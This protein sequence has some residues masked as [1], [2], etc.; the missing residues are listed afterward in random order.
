M[1]VATCKIDSMSYIIALIVIW[2][3]TKVIALVFN[4][5]DSKLTDLQMDIFLVTCLKTTTKV[6]EYILLLCQW[7]NRDSYLWRRCW[8]LWKQTHFLVSYICGFWAV[9]N[10]ERV[11]HLKEKL[12]IKKRPCICFSLYYIL[13]SSVKNGPS[14]QRMASITVETKCFIFK[15]KKNEWK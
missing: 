12:H 1:I 4:G 8:A 2:Q 5:S 15:K 3:H 13:F 9:S 10:Y 11:C 7:W 6:S 14:L